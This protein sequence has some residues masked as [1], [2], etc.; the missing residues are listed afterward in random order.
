MLQTMAGYDLQDPASVDAPLDDYLLQIDKGVKGWRIAI[1]V[2]AYIHKAN[3]EVVAAVN[4]AGRIFRSLGAEVTSVD[5]GNLSELALANGQMVA[6]D[7]AAFH[8]DRLSEHPDWFGA[9]VR[10]RL[11][12]GKAISSTDYSLARRKQSE[13]RR[14]AEGFFREYDLLLLPTTPITAPEIEG[15]DAIEQARQLTRFTAPFNLTGL[16]ALSLPCGFDSAGLPIGLQLVTGAWEEVRLLQAGHAFEN[17]TD[18]HRKFP[19]IDL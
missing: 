5:M 3:T 11:E 13:G 19:P 8:H 9:D 15:T 7:A 18:W 16:P 12:I 6:A 14:W 4:E 1:A 2:G 17:A 10:E